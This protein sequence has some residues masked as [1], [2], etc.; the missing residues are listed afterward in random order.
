M[1]HFKLT[2]D[3]LADRQAFRDYYGE[4]NCSCHMSAPCGSC[5]H[6]GNPHNQDEAADLWEPATHAELNHCDGIVKCASCPTVGG[7][8][9]QCAQAPWCETMDRPKFTCGCPDC[10]SSLVQGEG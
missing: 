3:A 5:T 4:G 8:D 1:Q 7:C 6:E 10:G 9:A 2:A